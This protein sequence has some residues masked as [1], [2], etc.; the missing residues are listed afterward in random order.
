MQANEGTVKFGA[1]NSAAHQ[2]TTL[3]VENKQGADD[4]GM[5]A[6]EGYFDNRSAAA[7]NEKSVLEKLVANN[8]KLAANNQS[9]VAMVKKLT[10]DIKNLERDNSRLK[11]GMQIRGRGPTLCHHCKKERYHQSDACYELATNKDKCPLVEESC[12]DGVGRSA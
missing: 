7:V 11:K 8:T 1:V 9:L 12:C 4:G 2:E 5:K 10:G 6:L 3:N